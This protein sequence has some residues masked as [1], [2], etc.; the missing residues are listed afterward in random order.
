MESPGGRNRA[1]VLVAGAVAVL[2]VIIGLSQGKLVG[3]NAVGPAPGAKPTRAPLVDPL[4][5]DPAPSLLSSSVIDEVTPLLEQQQEDTLTSVQEFWGED[6]GRQAEDDSFE[7]WLEI[8]ATTEP[9]SEQR[10]RERSERAH[11]SRSTRNTRAASWLAVHGCR[12]VWTSYAIRDAKGGVG[13]TVRKELNELLT[14]ASRIATAAQRQANPRASRVSP[15]P[16]TARP[17]NASCKCSY[18]SSA[19]LMATAARMYLG[20]RLP[21]NADR[22][23]AMEKQVAA[24]GLYQRRELASDVEEGARLGFLLGRYYNIT[25][26]Y[27]DASEPT[28]TATPTNR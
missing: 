27:G 13:T 16:S 6:K 25:R 11:I 26:G 23:V 22:Y 15:C 1:R 24:T 5:K 19:T 17:L 9:A 28:P 18:P 3:I 10:D 2:A 21:K 8:T 14:I 12:D 4:A 7:D 20:K